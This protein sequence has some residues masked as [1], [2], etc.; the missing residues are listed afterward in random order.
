VQALAVS[1]QDPDILMAGIELGGVLRSA[2]GGRTW[3]RHR[4]GAIRDC[5]SLKFHSTNGKWVYEGGGSGMA[6]SRDS[7]VTW[8]K[9]KDG[10]GTKYGW[11]VA[12]DPEK[13][14]VYY[15]SASVMPSLLRR[16]WEPPAHQDG[17][18]RTHI[19][20]AVNGSPWIKLDGGLP[21]PLDYM[22]YAL[23]TDPS[24]TGHLYAGLANGDVWHSGDYGDT[25][26]QLPLNLG[27]IHRTM[28][29]LFP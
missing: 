12:A 21:Q 4:R 15:L 23:V 7:G 2:D 27:S 1:P 5:H 14:E 13:P 8:E 18:A 26:T 11:M 24:A 22:A 25:W 20:R 10:L 29:M 19:Y 3:S 28:I 16:E 6:F 17:D 9:P